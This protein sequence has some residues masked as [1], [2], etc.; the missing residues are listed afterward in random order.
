M[1]HTREQADRMAEALRSLPADE[2]RRRFNKQAMVKYLSPELI[3]MQER[4]YSIEKIAA[5]L[6]A[7]GL[8][9]A[10]STLR[11]YLSRAKNNG[12]SRRRK[13]R[14]RRSGPSAT[15]RTSSRAVN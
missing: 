4:G 8:E 9:I 12:R 14:N 3:G 15:P 7:G 13:A 11:K 5:A 2:S 10:D 6:R 1:A